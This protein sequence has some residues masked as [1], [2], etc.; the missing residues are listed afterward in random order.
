MKCAKVRPLL[1]ALLDGELS[2]SQ[3]DVVASHLAACPACA[4][5]LERLEATAPVAPVVHL[6]PARRHQLHLSLDQ[7]LD[8]AEREPAPPARGWRDVLTVEVPVPR[9]LVFL[10]AAALLLAVG[11]AARGALSPAPQAPETAALE[12]DAPVAA[13][14][15]RPAAYTPQDGWF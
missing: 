2:R 14:L 9:G 8:R 7:A 1:V 10:Y 11:W 6:D 13:Q 5:H 4:A 12:A 3:E 15:H